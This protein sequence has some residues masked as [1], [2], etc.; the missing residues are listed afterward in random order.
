VR[1][2]IFSDLKALSALRKVAPKNKEL[3]DL[4]ET[5]IDG[6][7]PESLKKAVEKSVEKTRIRRPISNE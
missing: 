5:I 1:Q 6:K 2:S 7:N 3:I 4:L